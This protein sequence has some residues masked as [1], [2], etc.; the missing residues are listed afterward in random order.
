MT[1]TS[2]RRRL[3][4]TLFKTSCWP[5][6]IRQ[7]GEESGKPAAI[8]PYA[9]VILLRKSK[10][11]PKGHVSGGRRRSPRGPSAAHAARPPARG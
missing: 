3:A 8:A 11:A 4:V 2:V 10:L 7:S 1:N 5:L 9:R 6:S